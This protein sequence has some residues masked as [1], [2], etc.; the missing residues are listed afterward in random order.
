MSPQTLDE[1]RQGEYVLRRETARL[2]RLV[3][4]QDDPTDSPELLSE[5]DQAEEKLLDIE[6]QR[7]EAEQTGGNGG[8]VLDTKVESHLL[9]PETTGL[10]ARVELRM[11]FVPTAIAHLLEREEDPLLRCRVKSTDDKRTRRLRVSAFVERYAPPAV[12][13]VELKP[14]AEHTFDLLPIFDREETRQVTEITQATLNL[15]LEDLGGEIEPGGPERR[16]AVELHRSIP[17]WL[18]ARTCVP[19]AIRDPTTGAWRDMTPYFGAF[20]T[21]NAPAVMAFVRTAA[22]RHPQ[23]TLAGYQGKRE[24]VEPQVRAIFDALQTDAGITYVNS[25]IAFSPD[26]GSATQRVRLPRESLE[27]KQA[28]CI[29]G[30]VLYASLLEAVSLSPAIVVVP[31]HAFLAWETWEGSNEWRYVETTMIN[32]YSFE[33]ASASAEATAEHYEAN[34]GSLKGRFSRWPLRELRSVRRIMPME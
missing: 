27:D 29:D 11:E 4:D 12:E 33:E 30:T 3:F 2:R 19:F 15:L 9:G 16:G 5:L 8:V 1:L 10:E 25:V 13:T 24:E 31:G 34:E 23:K 22:D 18:L 6:Q 32:S 21:P 17:I 14:L 7:S 28:N 26:E 20:V